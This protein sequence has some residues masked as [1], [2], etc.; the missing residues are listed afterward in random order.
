M[1]KVDIKG[2]KA[3]N[4]MLLKKAKFLKKPKKFFASASVLLRK[5]ILNHF[6][7]EKSPTGKWKKSKRAI[8]EHGK[9]LQKKRRLLQDIQ[10]SAKYTST[11]MEVGTNIEYAGKHNMG[12]DGMPKRE[13]MWLSDTGE[14]KIGKAFVFYLGKA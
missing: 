13:F 10:S 2:A 8:K 3:L 6:K 5:D 7:Q 12:T 1:I 14:N 9:T 4:K 11:Y